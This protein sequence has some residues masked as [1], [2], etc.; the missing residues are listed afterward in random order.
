MTLDVALP[1]MRSL[2]PVRVSCDSF[3]GHPAYARLLADAPRTGACPVWITEPDRLQLP[4]DLQAA[5]AAVARADPEA[6][7][8]DRW[9][10]NCPFCGCRDPFDEFPGLQPAL[11]PVDDPVV[12]AARMTAGPARAHLAIVP[13][14][15]PADTVAALGWTGACDYRED[16]AGLSAVLRSWEDRFGAMLVRMDVSTLWVSVASPPRTADECRRVAA[17]HFTFCRDVDWEEP[18][19]LRDYAQTLLGNPTWR[20]WWD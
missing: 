1:P 4:A 2:G 5:A 9:T 15:R 17:E 14:S 18:R 20:F 13:V 16:V 6:F 11:S 8:A 19:P 12:A 10:Q 3:D 7:M